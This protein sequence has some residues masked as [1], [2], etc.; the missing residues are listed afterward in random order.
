MSYFPSGGMI[1]IFVIFLLLPILLPLAMILIPA[2]C[3]LCICD[4][5]FETMHEKRLIEE[6]KNRS[7]R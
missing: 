5:A 2:Y 6:S 7:K 1:S 4:C 3:L